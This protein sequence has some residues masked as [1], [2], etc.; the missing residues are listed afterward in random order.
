MEVK[1]KNHAMLSNYEVLGLLKDIQAGRGQKKP[2]KFQTNLATITY[3][4]IKCLE[5]WPC[6]HHTPSGLS[7]AM[8]A[9][10]P[11]GLTAAEK[12]QLINLCPSSAVEIQ[13]IVE[14]SE[15]RLSETQIEELLDLL[16]THIPGPDTQ[17][18][19]AE[20]EEEEE[21][22]QGDAYDVTDASA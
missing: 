22:D 16:A 19:Q 17:N 11:Y 21:E 1:S 4:T 18:E 15:E 2:N 13:L 10:A 6:A 20:E 12:L 7:A 8:K 5:N 14:E 3:E 9:L